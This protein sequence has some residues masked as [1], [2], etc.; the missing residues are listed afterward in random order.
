MMSAIRIFLILYKFLVRQTLG[1]SHCHLVKEGVRCWLPV[2]RDEGVLEAGAG[3]HHFW[4]FFNEESLKL[5]ALLGV[6][7]YTDS[8]PKTCRKLASSFG[9]KLFAR[10]A[11]YWSRIVLSKW[12]S[13]QRNLASDREQCKPSLLF[14]P[15]GCIIT[16]HRW[17]W[18][19]GATSGWM[20]WIG[21][22]IFGWGGV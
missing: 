5:V 22:I 10:C 20:D 12:I 15:F 6:R 3:Q 18:H 1:Q 7:C 4:D 9:Q 13:L 11:F 19:H 17:M 16:R 8:H 2:F 14:E 21:M